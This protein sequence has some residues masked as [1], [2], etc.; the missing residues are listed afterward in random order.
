MRRRTLALALLGL[1]GGLTPAGPARAFAQ[2]G[3][4]YTYNGSYGYWSGSAGPGVSRYAPRPAYPPNYAQQAAYYPS[5]PAYTRPTG[6]VYA[7]PVAR[8]CGRGR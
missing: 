1:F 6:R 8:P 3:Q 2:R 5:V 4:T 7:Q